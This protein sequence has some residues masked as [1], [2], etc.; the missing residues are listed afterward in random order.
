MFVF[1]D[2]G[3]LT[4]NDLFQPCHFPVKWILLFFFTGEYIQTH[5]YIHTLC[6]CVC[7]SWASTLF[8]ILNRVTS[9]WMRKYLCSSLPSPL[10]I[11]QDKYNWSHSTSLSSFRRKL[12]TDFHSDYNSFYF[13]ESVKSVFL[14]SNWYQHFLSFDFFEEEGIYFSIRCIFI[15]EENDVWNLMQRPRDN[16]CWESHE[17]KLFIFLLSMISF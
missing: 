16:D 15:V 8:L 11:C 14:F 2:L 4:Y 6:M 13:S 3:C 10:G 1:L 5:T 9:T 12:Y 7:I 17:G